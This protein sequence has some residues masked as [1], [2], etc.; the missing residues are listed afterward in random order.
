VDKR[1]KDLVITIGYLDRDET[2]LRA[3][4]KEGTHRPRMVYNNSKRFVNSA[5]FVVIQFLVIDF[6]QVEEE[7]PKGRKSKLF[8]NSGKVEAYRA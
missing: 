2:L 8:P 4:E 5:M 1:A 7:V 3:R 6:Y